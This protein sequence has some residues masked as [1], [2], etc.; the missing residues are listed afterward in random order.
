METFEKQKD[1]ITKGWR[2]TLI[3]RALHQTLK[4]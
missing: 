1:I 3:K 2:I 4:E